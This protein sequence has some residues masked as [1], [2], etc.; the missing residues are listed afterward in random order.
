[1]ILS[2]IHATI[3]LY[4]MSILNN[5]ILFEMIFTRSTT[6]TSKTHQPPKNPKIS[7][8]HGSKAFCDKPRIPLNKGAANRNTCTQIFK[9]E[10]MIHKKYRLYNLYIDMRCGMNEMLWSLWFRF[11]SV[12][13]KTFWQQLV[14]RQLCIYVGP[15]LSLQQQSLV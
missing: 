2:Y 10:K 3:S 13:W 15:S 12:C 4:N 11:F 7:E 14:C 9:N 8:F 1:M 5:K 6:G